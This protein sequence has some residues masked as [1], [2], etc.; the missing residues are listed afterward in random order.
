MNIARFIERRDKNTK[1][2]I[3]GDMRHCLLCK[4][5][6]PCERS[7]LDEI[8]VTH[9][10]MAIGL[11]SPDPNFYKKLYE[12]CKPNYIYV[13]KSPICNYCVEDLNINQDDEFKSS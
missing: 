8:F 12:L 7:S 5:H 13:K 3:Y 9:K 6:G 10:L 1:H 11:K 4:E 2:T